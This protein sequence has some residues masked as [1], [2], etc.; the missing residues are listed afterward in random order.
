[1]NGTPVYL[2]LAYITYLVCQNICVLFVSNEVLGNDNSVSKL[3]YRVIFFVVLVICVIEMPTSFN[4][5]LILPSSLS[6]L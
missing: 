3:F 4:L 2:K 1:M 6:K 5:C